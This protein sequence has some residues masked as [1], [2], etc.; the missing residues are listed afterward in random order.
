MPKTSP[1]FWLLLASTILKKNKLISMFQFQMHFKLKLFIVDKI[2]IKLKQSFPNTIAKH[3]LW[4][5]NFLSTTSTKLF[6]IAC[7]L[8]TNPQTL[9][10]HVE[11][12]LANLLQIL[13]KVFGAISSIHTLV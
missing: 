11:T 8:G 7:L 3:F 5:L 1:N 10:K 6:D 9:M 2:W 13:P 12:T 4:T